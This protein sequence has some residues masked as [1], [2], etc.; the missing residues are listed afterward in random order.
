MHI[1]AFLRLAG[2]ATDDVSVCHDREGKFCNTDVSH[3]AKDRTRLYLAYLQTRWSPPT[4]DP[5]SSMELRSRDL[6][7]DDATKSLQT[8]SCKSPG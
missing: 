1:A 5:A 8:S 6:S 7:P 3:D 2:S 4:G